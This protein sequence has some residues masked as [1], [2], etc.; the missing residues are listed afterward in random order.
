MAIEF[1]AKWGDS[2]NISALVKMIA[3]GRI[4]LYKPGSPINGGDK[5]YYKTQIGT[6]E[7]IIENLKQL[8]D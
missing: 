4:T 8:I 7:A 6:L 3:D 5:S 2:A 1:D